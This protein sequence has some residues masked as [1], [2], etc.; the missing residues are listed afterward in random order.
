MV[1]FGTKS[2]DIDRNGWL[3]LIVTNGHIFDTRIYGEEY[4][5]MPPQMLMSK[6]RRF[7]LTEVGDDSGY[8]DEIYLGRAMATLDFDRDGSIDILIGHLDKPVAL[9]D[10]QTETEGS[11]IQLELV[12]TVTERDA[13]GTR[14]VVTAG[15]E[16]FTHWVT[17]GD[18]Y[19]CSDEPVL[20]FG[21]GNHQQVDRVEIFW[22]NR[23]KQTFES[24][25]PGH[26][27]L[28]VEGQPEVVQR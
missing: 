4:F 24:L 28:V 13:I 15:G 3:D 5:Q 21:L 25:Q 2:I 20:D 12:G 6:G 27:Y 14:V 10:N 1:G 18:G 26:R 23:E 7:E 11:W 8:W 16:Q 9:L 17:A 22:P 19:F